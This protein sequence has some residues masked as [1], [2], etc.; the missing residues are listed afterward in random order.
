[1]NTASALT[2]PEIS[3]YTL[4]K[5]RLHLPL[6]VVVSFFISLLGL[7]C[8]E[9]TD[10]MYMCNLYGHRFADIYE[11]LSSWSSGPRDAIKIIF[12]VLFH[13]L[14]GAV[15][16][17]GTITTSIFLFAQV[18]VKAVVTTSSWCAINA[19]TAFRWSI[20]KCAVVLES[21]FVQILDTISLGFS[22]QWKSWAIAIPACW[23][24]YLEFH[25]ITVG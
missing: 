5:R 14:Y 9:T 23:I 22:L 18:I 2:E 24:L 25:Q 3:K 7:V 12:R 19:L 4:S 8:G 15:L 11:C 21:I 10:R 17:I 1:M 20:K 13:L 6:S 16:F